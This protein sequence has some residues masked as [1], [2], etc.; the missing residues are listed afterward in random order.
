MT[1][2][3]ILKPHL[4]V[5]SAAPCFKRSTLLNN[6]NEIDSTIF[7]K[8]ESVVTCIILYGDESFKYEVNLLILN[9]TIDFVLSTKR[10]D[11]PLYLL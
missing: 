2:A 1:V 7:N 8:C 5:F 11:E 3:S 4:M 9:A 6:I 10:F